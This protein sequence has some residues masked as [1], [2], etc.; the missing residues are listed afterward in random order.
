LDSG[1]NFHAASLFRRKVPV[2]V[3]KA[4][5]NELCQS[6]DTAA[7]IAAAMV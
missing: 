7:E 2:P 4:A 3:H 1:D 5:R 6:L